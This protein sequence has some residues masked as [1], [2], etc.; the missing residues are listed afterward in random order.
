MWDERNKCVEEKKTKPPDETLP[1]IF[2]VQDKL[3]LIQSFPFL[4]LSLVL[5]NLA[6][7][8]GCLPDILG[9]DFDWREA[10][11]Q[12]ALTPGIC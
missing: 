11:E 10:I 9:L 3:K 2:I 4:L 12:S 1:P 7:A 6:L 8:T 5:E